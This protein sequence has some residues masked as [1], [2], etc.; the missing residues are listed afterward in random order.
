MQKCILAK[1]KILVIKVTDV[2]EIPCRFNDDVHEWSNEILS[3]PS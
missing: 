2:S 3:V 1:N